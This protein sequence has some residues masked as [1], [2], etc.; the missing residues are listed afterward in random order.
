VSVISGCDVN[1]PASDGKVPL[2]YVC[3]GDDSREEDVNES[4]L[5]AILDLL[6]ERGADVDVMDNMGYTPLFLACEYDNVAIVK[7]LVRV[8]CDVNKQS[9]C[10][11]SPLKA[12]C[13]NAKF[14]PH[15]QGRAFRNSSAARG[16]IDANGYPSMMITKMLLQA[17][18]DIAEA[19][20]LPT[21]IQFNDEK[22][23]KE[24]LEL[25]MDINMLDDNM[26]TPLGAACTYTSVSS[27]VGKRGCCFLFF[28]FLYTPVIDGT[29]YGMV[30]IVRPSVCVSVHFLLVRAI[31]FDPLN[32]I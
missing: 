16:H 22:L 6:L 29:Y 26:C 23:L 32:I 30:W 9:V 3:K 14:W 2:H 18:A 15:W 11:D 24:L 1:I 7:S 13:R 28:V 5:L 19:T 12:A 10:G 20:M 17:G 8:G 21:A 25:G 4:E 31:T 27:K